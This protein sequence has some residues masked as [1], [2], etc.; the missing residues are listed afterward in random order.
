MDMEPPDFFWIS[1]SRD[2]IADKNKIEVMKLQIEDDFI[3]LFPYRNN[4]IQ[5]VLA[6]VLFIP[7]GGFVIFSPFRNPCSPD[8]TLGDCS[9]GSPFAELLYTIFMVSIGVFIIIFCLYLIYRYRKSLVP[10]KGCRVAFTKDSIIGPTWSFWGAPEGEIK[11][12]EITNFKIVQS[13]YGIFM[14]IESISREMRL[15]ASFLNESGAFEKVYNRIAVA[16]RKPS[17]NEAAPPEII[18][19]FTPLKDQIKDQEHILF[20]LLYFFITGS[21]ALVFGSYSGNQTNSD[22]LVVG[23][24]IPLSGFSYIISRYYKRI[25]LDKIGRVIFFLF[26]MLFGLFLGFVGTVGLLSF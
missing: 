4:L 17:F 20:S 9:L 15:Q 5:I 10:H 26:F 2:I 22:V 7:A 16:L 12:S 11:L 8:R 18:K 13:R 25:F 23:F 24:L 19:A 1:N 14:K 3:E 21:L 6:C